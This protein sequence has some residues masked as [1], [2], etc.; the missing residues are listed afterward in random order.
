MA[1]EDE[2]YA[3]GKLFKGNKRTEFWV[4]YFK[5]KYTSLE[6]YR[7]VTSLISNGKAMYTTNLTVRFK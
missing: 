6:I 5:D 4:S 7:A 1:I 3:A 2:L